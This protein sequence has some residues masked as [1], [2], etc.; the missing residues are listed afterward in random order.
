MANPNFT[1]RHEILGVGDNT[2]TSNQT[3][4]QPQ[5]ITHNTLGSGSAPHADI[6]AR[7]FV[8]NPG[9][10]A[11]SSCRSPAHE[12]KAN[13]AGATEM[14]DPNG[15]IP[16][17]QDT[18]DELNAAQS[19]LATTEQDELPGRRSGIGR[20]APGAH[21]EDAAA[22]VSTS[23]RGHRNSNYAPGYEGAADAVTHK[24]YNADEHRPSLLAHEP[25]TPATEV[26][27][28]VGNDGYNTPATS[29]PGMIPGPS[30]GQKAK[31]PFAK[32]HGAGEV[33]RG[34]VAAAADSFTGDKAKQAKDEEI[35]R[36][37][38]REFTDGRFDRAQALRV[39]H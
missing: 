22:G 24:S 5:D 11:S 38:Q 27:P 19:D 4:L 16:T 12:A 15:R 31:A 34:N 2:P 30:L 8:H 9:T 23:Q 3:S 36:K 28:D 14:G 21:L 26:P 33:L 37:G 7:D 17:A 6:G 18:H 13:T 25:V 1:N 39:E 35:V 32:I 20:S 10:A 29:G